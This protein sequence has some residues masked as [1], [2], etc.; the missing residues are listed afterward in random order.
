MAADDRINTGVSCQAD[1]ADG[2]VD[3]CKHAL[4]VARSIDVEGRVNGDE[5]IE[6]AVLSVSRW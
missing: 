1:L 2:R 4:Q 5:R 6:S 3:R